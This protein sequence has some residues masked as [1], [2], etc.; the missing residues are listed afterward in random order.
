MAKDRNIATRANIGLADLTSAVL[1]HYLPKDP[2][3]HVSTAW[4]NAVLTD[5]QVKY[6]ALDVYATAA[7]FETFSVIPVGQPVTRDTASGTRV[8]LLNRPATFNNVNVTKT[9]IIINVHT[10]LVPAYLGGIHPTALQGHLHLSRLYHSCVSDIQDFTAWHNRLDYTPS[11]EQTFE[12]SSC[13]AVSAAKA[14]AIEVHAC[15]SSSFNVICS[16]VLGDIWHLM[17]QFKI[18]VHHGMRRPFTRALRDAILLP[19]EN[20]KAAVEAVLKTQGCRVKRFAPPPE[21][22]CSCVSAVVKMYGP[23]K[24]AVT[25]QLLFND[26]SWEKAVN[27]LENVRMGFYSDPPGVELYMVQG[28]DKEELHLSLHSCSYNASPRFAV[29]LLR[30]YC[31]CHNLRVGTL[32]R[33]GKVHQGSYDIWCINCR[34]HL[35]DDTADALASS[36]GNRVHAGWVNGNDF[37]RSAETFRIMLLSEITSSKLGMLVYHP[38]F[39]KAEKIKHAHLMMQQNTRIAILLLHTA[40]ERALYHIFLRQAGRPFAGPKQ[41]NWVA[42]ANEWAKHCDG[43]KIFYKLPKHLKNYHK[44]WSEN[45]NE[46]NSVELHKAAYNTICTLLVPPEGS[47]PSIQASTGQSLADEVQTGRRATEINATV[48]D[49][50]TDVILGHHSARQSLT[51]FYYGERP[52]PVQTSQQATELSKGKKRARRSSD[53][54][55]KVNKRAPRT[56]TSRIPFP[57]S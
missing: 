26:V 9:R 1:H 54:G 57:P 17:D 27:V 51:Q 22:L 39:A 29:N 18:S 53:E 34:V 24:D 28:R 2:S 38:A 14:A 33:T 21:I 37:E 30:D 41:P 12:N 36:V 31:L 47:V 5:D 7:I 49:W 40:E 32:N 6:A 10:I 55:P 44:T 19:D 43:K 8:H 56:C 20:D 42:M 16:Q 46:E 15:S 45:R 52:P 50:Q 25:G 35:L 4:D 13:D 11:E 48:S 3:V 23:L